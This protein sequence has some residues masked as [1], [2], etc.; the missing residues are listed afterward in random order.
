MPIRARGGEERTDERIALVRDELDSVVQDLWE[1]VLSK[2][3]WHSP[4]LVMDEAHH[5]KNPATNLARQLQARKWEDEEDDLKTGEGALA[6]KFDRMLFLTATPFQLGHQELVH[7]LRRFGDVRCDAVIFG[8]HN[9]FKEKLNHLETALTESQRAAIRLQKCWSC[10]LPED[11]PQGRDP[12]KWWRSL[13]SRQETEPDR[14]TRRQ[15]ALVEAFTQARKNCRAAEEKLRPW[16]IRHNKGEFW[17]GT[18]VRRRCRVEGAA[19]RDNGNPAQGL[20]VPPEQLLPFFLAARSAVSPGQDLLGEALCS[21]Y[22]ALRD[23]RRNGEPERDE[24]DIEQTRD[25]RTPRQQRR[26]EEVR[27]SHATWYLQQFDSVLERG[28]GEDHPKIAATVK[29]AV[30]LWEQGEKV[31]IFAFYCQTC[32]ALRV[33]I[34]RE[35]ERRMAALARRRFAD[36]GRPLGDEQIEAILKSIRR[37]YFDD[38]KSLGGQALNEALGDILDRCLEAADMPPEQQQQLRGRLIKVMRHFLRVKTT[39]VRYFPI[40]EYKTKEPSVAVRSMLDSRDASDV[41]LRSKVEQF[42]DFLVKRC[43]EAERHEY[44]DA[45]ARMNTGAMRVKADD[46]QSKGTSPSGS[47]RTLAAVREATGASQQEQRTRLMRAFNTPFF[48]DIFVCSQVMGEGVDLQRY[49]CHVIHHD[50]DWNPS[51]IEQ[52]TGRVDRL[53]C[54]AERRRPIYVYLPYLSGAADERQFRGMTEREQWFRI[55]M[56][57][58]EVAR[59]IPRDADDDRPQLPR[60]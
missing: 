9:G 47:A 26:D 5:L 6:K 14:L 41:S 51:S 48:P 30:D 57:Q 42:I 39:L 11:G 43:S 13:L 59:L 3:R 25:A 15:R 54:K 16:L 40:P 28:A 55:V 12:D 37:H 56:G 36:A 58:D 8:D 10:L 24:L 53:A 17:P 20:E 52:R 19:I 60:S 21:S 46:D 7:V 34:S 45:V 1:H 49:C 23:T 27:L 2:A 4:L 44:L 33:H 29:K 31:L 35:I 32:R 38:A 22:E 50:L 18:Q